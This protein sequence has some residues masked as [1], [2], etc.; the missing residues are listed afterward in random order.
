MKKVLALILAGAVLLCASVLAEEEESENSAPV[1]EE[2]VEETETVELE[3][4]GPED[5]VCYQGKWVSIP[6]VDDD[7]IDVFLPVAWRES[8]AV[9]MAEDAP[10][11][12]AEDAIYATAGGSGT[13]GMYV[14]CETRD[15]ET[16]VT[17]LQ[18]EYVENYADAAV[19]TQQDTEYVR[20]TDAE[21]DI[22]VALL[23]LGNHV[24][25]FCFGPASD[26]DVTEYI[27]DIITT[28]GANPEA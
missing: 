6:G 5:R 1:A 18:E 12:V 11:R 25:S 27:E 22:V 20:Y 26:T 8:D 14:T 2:A 13:W 23:P 21:Q 28:I 7:S 3:T 15:A 16:D 17:T 24:Y 9:E 10:F 19:V 4:N